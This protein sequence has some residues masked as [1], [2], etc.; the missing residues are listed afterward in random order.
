M[1]TQGIARMTRMKSILDVSETD[2]GTC[3]TSK[4]TE[5]IHPEI[6]AKVLVVRDG[7][8][9][10]TG[11]V[12]LNFNHSDQR[13]LRRELRLC[14][15]DRWFPRIGSYP[16][17]LEVFV[18]TEKIAENQF[19]INRRMTYRVINGASR[20]LPRNDIQF[21]IAYRDWYKLRKNE[22]YTPIPAPAAMAAAAY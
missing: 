10:Y 13:A 20:A 18:K 6:D 1:S 16:C 3:S 5:G 19:V 15:M 17:Q 11:R 4:W 12:P 8:F 21:K 14:F 22:F 9:D 7:E 2:L